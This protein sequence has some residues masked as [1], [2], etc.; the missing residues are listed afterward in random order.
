[1]AQLEHPNQLPALSPPWEENQRLIPGLLAGLPTMPNHWVEDWNSI[2]ILD[3]CK[4]R[5][6]DMGLNPNDVET[7]NVHY[8]DCIE[9]WIMCRH[10][11][12]LVSKGMMIDLWSRIPLAMREV[13]RHFGVWPAGGDSAY[14][15]DDNIVFLGPTV[16]RLPVIIHEVAHSVDG[17]LLQHIDSS[18]PFSYGNTWRTIV[19]RDSAI[20]TEYGRTSWPENFAESMVIAVANHNFP[21]GIGSMHPNPG[22]VR[23]AYTGLHDLIPE[24]IGSRAKTQCTMRHLNGNA[25]LKN[26]NLRTSIPLPDTGFLSDIEVI[27]SIGDAGNATQVPEKF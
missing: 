2:H 13:V 19:G 10:K 22:P 4:E 27:E 16:Y 20:V 17:Y 11:D 18:R 24:V 26:N 25:V 9:P 1:M 23:N 3:W 15:F 5:T 8:D 6:V 14:S 21:G 7:W 12:S